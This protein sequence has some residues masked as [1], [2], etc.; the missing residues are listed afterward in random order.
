MNA[1]Q[2]ENETG[3]SRRNLRFYEQQGLIKPRRNP[4]N[5]YREYSQEDIKNLKAIR[6]LRMLDVPLE[7]IGAY[8]KGSV[9][10]AEISQSQEQRLLKK[11]QELRN[12]LY[13]CRQ[14]ADSDVSLENM[15]QKMEQP[16][17]Q[18]TLFSEWLHDYQTVEKYEAKRTFSFAPDIP[19]TNAREFTDA[20]CRYGT[21]NDQNLVITREGMYPEFT[22]DGIPY[23]AE[24]TYRAIGSPLPVAVISCTI[25]DPDLI[26]PHMPSKKLSVLSFLRNWWPI[27]I[28]II[29]AAIFCVTT[30]MPIWCAVVAAIPAAAIWWAFSQSYRIK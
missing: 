17:I 16:E 11:Q 8:L 9:T 29:L 22:V 20:L 7:D 6:T 13:F 27:L 25:Q 23:R 28:F 21:E 1:K 2:A 19:V 26:K 12:A 18:K 30:H 4:Q 3:I 24:L 10:L 15:L 5:D 14:L